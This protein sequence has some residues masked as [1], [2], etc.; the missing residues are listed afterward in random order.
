[1]QDY[2][3]ITATSPAAAGGT[4]TATFPQ[5]GQEAWLID[6]AIASCTSSTETALRLYE[7][8]PSPGFLLSGTARGNFD[9]AD[10]PAGVLI[11]P[12]TQLLAVWTLASD[13]AV[14]T[15]RLQVRVLRAG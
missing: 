7:G 1:M 6:R 5:L 9:E 13:G 12:G 10:Y 11:S 2:R 8:N 15:L 3:Y 4:A 14:G